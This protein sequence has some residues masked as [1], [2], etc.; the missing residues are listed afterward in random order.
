MT[1]MKKK[2][3]KHSKII[4]TLKFKIQAIEMKLSKE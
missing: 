3:K 2:W 4:Q 1:K